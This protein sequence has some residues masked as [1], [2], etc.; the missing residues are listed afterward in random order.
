MAFTN[1]QPSET[2]FL[3]LDI[4]RHCLECLLDYVYTRECQLT[5]ETVNQMI[6]AAKFYQMTD[7]FH[8]CC[9]Y[10]IENLNDEN[11][12]SL[13]DFAKLH[14]NSKLFN[15]TYEYIM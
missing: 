1:L 8:Y 9:E 12:F 5:L 4:D 2:A 14:F 10:L 3:Q 15:I 6:D 13:Y 11:I 7:L